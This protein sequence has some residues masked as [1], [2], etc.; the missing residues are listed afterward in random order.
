MTGWI[1]KKETFGKKIKLL[2]N[3]G[4]IK[5]TER[6]SLWDTK[7]KT[8]INEGDQFTPKQ[9]EEPIKW[10]RYISKDKYDTDRYSRRGEFLRNIL[11]DGEQKR[12]GYPKTVE[13][14]ILELANTLKELGKD[15][16]NAY[17]VINRTGKKL[18]TK[19]SVGIQGED[20]QSEDSPVSVPDV[21]EDPEELS[22][23]EQAVV[24]EFRKAIKEKDLDTT[25][26]QVREAYI[27]GLVT[28]T[29]V[30]EERATQLYDLHLHGTEKED[31]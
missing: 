19:Y 8:F 28:N 5:G 10:D 21:S 20:K 7:Q 23:R 17:L 16:R 27:K 31:G 15:I 6:V 18:N 25:T 13:E 11:I 1:N 4:T 3:D 30:S 29:G 14:K 22:V 12:V 24:S 9:G 2:S 26:K